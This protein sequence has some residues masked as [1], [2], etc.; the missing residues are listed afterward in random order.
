MNPEISR[1]S[2]ISF[3]RSGWVVGITPFVQFCP[4]LQPPIM[5]FP[6]K[7]NFTLEIMLDYLMYSIMIEGA[8]ELDKTRHRG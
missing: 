3:F 8:A 1:V 7:L 5:I 6:E 2:E 4:I